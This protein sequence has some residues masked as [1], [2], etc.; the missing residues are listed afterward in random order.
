MILIGET[1][2]RLDED[3]A[4]LLGRLDSPTF[5]YAKLNSHSQMLYHSVQLQAEELVRLMATK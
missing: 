4:D 2:Q 5:E 1:L 3:L